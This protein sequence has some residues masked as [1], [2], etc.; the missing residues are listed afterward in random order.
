[1]SYDQNDIDKFFS[2]LHEVPE[3][4][5]IKKVHQLIN[6]PPAQA[7]LVE[8]NSIKPFVI[9]S[10]VTS[11]I[12]AT[13]WFLWPSAEENESE[14]KLERIEHFPEVKVPERKTEI[15]LESLPVDVTTSEEVQP[16]KQS[17]DA[18]T[19]E[20]QPAITPSDQQV[21]VE[22]ADEEITRRWNRYKHV[23]FVTIHY[24]C[25]DLIQGYL[26]QEAVLKR[27]QEQHAVVRRAQWRGLQ[28]R[29]D[30]WRG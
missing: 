18:A 11:V 29:R 7:R 21:M 28:R 6:H 17:G 12:I 26:K 20:S 4:V 24:Q 14:L 25:N 16:I 9:M 5:S 2:A 3:N 22:N 10:I 27:V 23:G 15:V 1:M 19:I 8:T 30:Q 13:T